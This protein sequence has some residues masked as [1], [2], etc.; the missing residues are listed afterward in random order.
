MTTCSDILTYVAYIVDVYAFLS[1][2]YTIY[3]ARQSRKHRRLYEQLMLKI[4]AEKGK[5]IFL[6]I[7]R[8]TKNKRNWYLGGEGEKVLNPVRSFFMM[9]TEVVTLFSKELQQKHDVV[10]RKVNGV[11]QWTYLPSLVKDVL[12]YLYDVNVYVSNEIGVKAK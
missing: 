12:N 7:S 6:L 5:E 9:N 11:N 2:P 8:K 1:I 10:V 3:K 4:Y